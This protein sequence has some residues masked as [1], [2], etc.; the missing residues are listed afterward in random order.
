MEANTHGLGHN[1]HAAVQPD[2]LPPRYTQVLG[3]LISARLFPPPGLRS[4]GV[5]SW[6]AVFCHGVFQEP[7]PFRGLLEDV[8]H[9]GPGHHVERILYSA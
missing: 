1:V 7:L 9:D 2:Q 6:A 5:F 8:V 4:R 3:L